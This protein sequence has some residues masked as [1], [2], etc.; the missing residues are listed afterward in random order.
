MLLKTFDKLCCLLEFWLKSD[1]IYKLHSPSLF[2]IAEKVFE[3]NDYYYDFEIIEQ[4]YYSLTTINVPIV[5]NE[6]SKIRK[7]TGKLGGFAKKAMHHPEELFKLYKFLKLYEFNNILELG[8]CFGLSA[9]AISLASPK[10]KIVSV[11]GNEQFYELAQKFATSSSKITFKN[12]TFK[13]YL[14]GLTDEEFDLVIIDG[15]HQYDSTIYNLSII[16]RHLTENAIIL[17]DDIHWSSG[18]YRA[19][20][21]IL[22]GSS[23]HCSLETL[24]WGFLFCDRSLNKGNYSLIPSNL[25]YWQKFI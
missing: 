12:Q 2:H 19:W 9:R 17:I 10:S 5:D 15:D 7:Q 25:K 24:R 8:S 14:A 11:E 13:N 23:F 3:N 1:T 6:F 18:M 16:Q 4:A 20:K 22:S 21:E